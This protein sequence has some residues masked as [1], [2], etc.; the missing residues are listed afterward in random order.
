M[1][2]V[3]QYT[4]YNID[5]IEYV[6]LYF[7]IL[8]YIANILILFSFKMYYKVNSKSP[9]IIY[10]TLLNSLLIAKFLNPYSQLISIALLKYSIILY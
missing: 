3:S 5:Y 7:T 1:M 8:I 10:H 2:I 4:F 9:L 6:I